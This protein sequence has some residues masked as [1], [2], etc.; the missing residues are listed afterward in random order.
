V[1]AGLDMDGAKPGYKRVLIGP[2]L[3][4]GLTYARA[5]HRSMYGTV[6]SGWEIRF[7]R[8]RLDVKV[9]PNASA[10]VRLPRAKADDAMEGN[11]KVATAAGVECV[12]QDGEA[13]LVDLGSGRYSFS[14]PW[15]Q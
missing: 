9:P 7:G 5:S 13:V 14:Y 6:A 4:G 8:F 3:G 15:R 1:V 11:A 10:T 12:A 2:Q